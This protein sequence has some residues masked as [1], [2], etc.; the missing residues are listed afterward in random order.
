MTFIKYNLKCF[1]NLNLKGKI[2]KLLQAS[3]TKHFHD[4]GA[5]KDFLGY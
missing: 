1:I 5:G 2:I 4:F 3:K